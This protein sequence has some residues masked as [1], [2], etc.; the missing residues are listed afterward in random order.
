MS[1]R[2]ETN[3][4]SLPPFSLSSPR[5]DL[6]SFWGRMRL[7]VQVTSPLSLLHSTE[8]ILQN[9]A[10]L[11]LVEACE[12]KGVDISD[13]K[14][15][16]A[17]NEK[18]WNAREIVESAIHPTSGEVLP[19]PF[20]VS[21]IAPVNIPIA[22]G[23]LTTPASNV[24]LTLG[25]HFINQSYNAGCNYF[26]RSGSDLSLQEMGVAYSLAV[27]SACSMA[28]GLGKLFERGPKSL[29]RFGVAIPIV[30]TA[31]ASVSNLA[32]TRSGEAIHGIPVTDEEG[33]IRG[34]SKVAGMKAIAQTAIGRCCLVPAATL[35]LPTSVMSLLK[36]A[37]LFPKN[38]RLALLLEL[39]TIYAALQV[40]LPAALAVFP[41]TLSM[42]ANDLEEE[43]HSLKDS[44]GRPVKVLSANKGL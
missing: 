38:K 37:N 14:A 1:D 42:D 20:R 33:K 16:P 40:A 17:V 25:L 43:F 27:G 10:L 21:A 41:Q 26:N 7:F 31:A 34:H 29:A 6:S 44:K 23:M 15:S 9:K 24:P 30:A 36:S 18:L 22:W 32:F 3:A 11:K 2:V 12:A 13:L 39:G 5:F 28:F 8:T 4:G 35:L 19:S